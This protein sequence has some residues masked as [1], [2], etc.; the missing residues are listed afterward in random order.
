M[1]KTA[2][3]L[4]LFCLWATLP[5]FSQS[6]TNDIP[7]AQLPKEV[8]SVLEQYVSILANSSD[9]DQCAEKFVAVAGGTLVNEDG[10][11]L[12][13]TV[14]D[15]GLKKDFNNMKH[16]ANPIKLTRVNVS[17]SNGTGYGESAVKGKIYKVWID[18]KSKDLGMPAPISIIVPE[19]HPTINTPKVVNIGSL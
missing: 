8:K 13:T 1:K 7:V 12:R 2:Y 14:K 16:Y 3:S 5:A 10:Q 15:F 4:V 9:L 17:T 18:K 6:K 11:S 19:G